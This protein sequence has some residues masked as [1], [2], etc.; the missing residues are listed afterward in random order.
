[1]EQNALIND[2]RE[3][4][5]RIELRIASA[6]QDGVTRFIQ[7]NADVKQRMHTA[8]LLVLLVFQEFQCVMYSSMSRRLLNL[9]FHA[10]FSQKK[11]LLLFSL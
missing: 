2:A 3:A 1:M 4:R 8:R 5:S 7:R 9:S 11:I 6:L 10:C